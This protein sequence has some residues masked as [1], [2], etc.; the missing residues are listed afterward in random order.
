MSQKT[1]KLGSFRL[2]A[3]AVTTHLCRDDVI[4]MATGIAVIALVM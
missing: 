4:S 1:L 3:Q 2:E